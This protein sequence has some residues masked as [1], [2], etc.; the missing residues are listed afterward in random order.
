MMCMKLPYKENTIIK[1]EKLTKYLL[2]LI[3]P[4]GGSKAKFFRGIGFNNTNLEEFEQELY[5]IGKNE[6][7]KDIKE[8]GL[9]KGDI[10]AVVNIYN[11]GTAYEVEFVA[12]DGTTKALLTL[13]ATDIR[14][15]R[16]STTYIS[17]THISLGTVS[18]LTTF[19]ISEKDK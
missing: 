7:V 13:K 2:N 19:S 8:H 1:R 11:T 12:S 16:D 6:N 18:G 14:K 17:S 15:H 9:T 10:G 5:R 3:H 4:V